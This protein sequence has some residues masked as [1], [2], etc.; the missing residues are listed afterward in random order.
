MT[1]STEIERRIKDN[2][3]GLRIERDRDIQADR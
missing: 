2:A 3:L 1:R